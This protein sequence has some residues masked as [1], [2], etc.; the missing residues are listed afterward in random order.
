MRNPAPKRGSAA[1][2][3]AT[4]L[5]RC[6][7]RNNMKNFGLVNS[8]SHAGLTVPRRRPLFTPMSVAFD[9]YPQDTAWRFVVPMGRLQWA[10]DCTLAVHRWLPADT[11]LHLDTTRA[12]QHPRSL[13]RRRLAFLFAL[14][15]L[16]L[17][18]GASAQVADVASQNSALAAADQLFVSGRS[19]EA[20]EQY[21]AIVKSDPRLVPAQV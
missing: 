17:P 15:A 18:I 10:R 11:M 3:P 5:R 2:S 20:A 4:D 9:S 16:G 8:Q 6:C 7:D 21:Q 12:L 19:A 1:Q 14:F 13:T